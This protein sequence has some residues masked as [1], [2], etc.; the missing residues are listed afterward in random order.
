[1]GGGTS[2]TY[3]HEEEELVEEDEDEYDSDIMQDAENL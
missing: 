2:G 3:T 1:M